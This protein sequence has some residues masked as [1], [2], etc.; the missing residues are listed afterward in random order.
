MEEKKKLSVLPINPI[1]GGISIGI[2][3]L[4]NLSGCLQ[5]FT[6]GIGSGF[7]ED[8]T[9]SAKAKYIFSVLILIPAILSF[10]NIRVK[11]QV[12]QIIALALYVISGF[13]AFS[14]ELL[15]DATISM[16]YWNEISPSLIIMDL[17][18]VVIG[19]VMAVLSLIPI[20]K[21]N[22]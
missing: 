10:V 3:I 13:V 5:D 12:L 8:T 9:N 7:M 4:V 1:L 20:V 21:H 11:S 22:K 15:L 19:V 6:V 14:V 16:D 2:S 17:L 18:L